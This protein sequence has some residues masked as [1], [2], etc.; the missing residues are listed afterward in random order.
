[1]PDDQREEVK[2]VLAELMNQVARNDVLFY[3]MDLKRET[4][5]ACHNQIT[6]QVHTGRFE[7]TLSITMCPRYD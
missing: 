3:N 4:E 1:M 2:A 5:P 6:N 7:V